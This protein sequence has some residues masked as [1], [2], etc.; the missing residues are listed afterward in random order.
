MAFRVTQISDNHLSA[1]HGFARTNWEATRLYL[2]GNASDLIVST[3]DIVVDDPDEDDTRAFARA[4]FDELPAP[5]QVVPGN[6]DIGDGPPDPW[7]DQPVTASRIDA[8]VDTWGADRFVTDIEGWRLIG[9]NSILMGSGL[10]ALEDAHDAWL[11]EELA[12]ADGRH[13]AMFGH[14]PVYVHGRDD[15]ATSMAMPPRGRDRLLG[16]ID[17]HDVALVATG[18]LHDFRARIDRSTTFLWCPTSAFVAPGGQLDPYGG[19]RQIGL[20]EFDFD[21]AGVTWRLVRPEGAEEST[22]RPITEAHRSIR[23]SPPAPWDPA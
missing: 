9:Y 22:V 13:I 14:K 15:P 19:I 1:R 16:L 20:V 5:W 8:F 17:E 23:Y 18:H 12:G 2:E 11:A 6:H 3:G 21:T 7:Q 4:R 10:A